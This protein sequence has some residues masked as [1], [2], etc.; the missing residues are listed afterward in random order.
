M[1]ERQSQ[2]SWLASLGKGW[3]SRGSKILEIPDGLTH[4]H[5]FSLCRKL[6]GHFPVCR[7]LRVAVA[8]IKCLAIAVTKGW[9]D[10]I[11]NASVIY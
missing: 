10:R 5:I 1:T 6:V 3:H 7:W 4:R 2:S 9:D 11:K 8:F